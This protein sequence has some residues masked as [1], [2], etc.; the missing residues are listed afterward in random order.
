MVAVQGICWFGLKDQMYTG[1]LIDILFKAV[2]K[3][4]RA[5]A[6]L[7]YRSQDVEEAAPVVTGTST[8]EYREFG[9][10]TE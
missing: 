2:G 3:A 1:R 4:E 10:E 5:A 7:P 8:D 9:S 6:K